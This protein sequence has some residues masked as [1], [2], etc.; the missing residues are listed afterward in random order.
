MAKSDSS[1][2]LRLREEIAAQA[3]RLIAEDGIEDFAV[4]KRKAAKIIGAPDRIMPNNSE[5]EDALRAYHSLYQSEEQAERLKH[6]RAIALETMQ[7][8]SIFKPR[9]VGPVLTGLASRYAQV[10]IEIFAESA[11]DVEIFLIN[12][13]CPYVAGEKRVMLRERIR[14]IPVYELYAEDVTVELS[15]YENDDLRSLPKTRADGAVIERA[16]LDE[17]KKLLD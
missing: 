2:R 15:V 5:V 4:A 3:A 10:N 6:F 1:G 11:K 7:W 12:E 14:S 9:L 13:N 8:I 17:V 16:S